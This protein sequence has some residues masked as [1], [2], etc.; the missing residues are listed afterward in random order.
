MEHKEN[1]LV[2]SEMS[3]LQNENQMVLEGYI[4]LSVAKTLLDTT[5]F[6]VCVDI[7][8]CRSWV[9][10]DKNES[11]DAMLDTISQWVFVSRLSE[12][13]GGMIDVWNFDDNYN[14]LS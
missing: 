2:A 6:H 7:S 1:L 13:G 12:G 3:W 5:L 9:F 14:I 8:S 11:S 10:W 4:N